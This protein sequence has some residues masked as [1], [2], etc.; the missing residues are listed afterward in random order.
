MNPSIFREY[1][2]R[3]IY[4]TQLNEDT[5]FNIGRA[6]V[7]F[8]YRTSPPIADYIRER[9]TMRTATRWL[10]TPIVYGIKYPESVILI[11][12]GFG[13]VFGVSRRVRKDMGRG[14]NIVAR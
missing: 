14:D 13:A 6:F 3:G 2:I 1:D 10:L 4:P 12:V 11:V 5:A 8:Y 7:S 9:E